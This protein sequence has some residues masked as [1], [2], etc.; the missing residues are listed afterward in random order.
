MIYPHIKF[1]IPSYH[2]LLTIAIELKT[3]HSLHAAATLFN[4]LKKKSCI[5]L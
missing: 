4:I 1:H 3:K 2:G 5:F